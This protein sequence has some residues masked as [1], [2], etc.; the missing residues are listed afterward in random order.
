MSR[1]LAE[2]RVAG[3]APIF[4]ALGDET[5]LALLARLSQGGPASISAL[6]AAFEPMTRQ[7]VTKHLTV[8]AEAGVIDA[9]GVAV[10]GGDMAA[11][12]LLRRFG[13]AE[14]VRASCYLYTTTEEI[15]R[16][17]DV[18]RHHARAA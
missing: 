10:R 12:P 18:L 15:D 7:G 5:R 3:A 11:L 14:A 1:P 6:A 8:L 4:A 9:Q 2:S 13:I 17:M 16:M